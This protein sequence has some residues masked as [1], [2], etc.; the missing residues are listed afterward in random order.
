MLR[1]QNKNLAQQALR[2][3]LGS[4]LF[5][6]MVAGGVLLDLAGGGTQAFYLA[7]VILLSLFILR[8]LLFSPHLFFPPGPLSS[9]QDELRRLREEVRR[10]K[11]GR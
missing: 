5:W 4:R 2:E 11:R 8:S 10:L 1:A 7:G 9:T 6:L 3:V